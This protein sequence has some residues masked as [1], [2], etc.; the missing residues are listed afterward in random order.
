MRETVIA[1]LKARSAGNA[2]LTIEKGTGMLE[3]LFGGLEGF[4][5]I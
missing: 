3:F 1:C 5:G 4:S 2:E